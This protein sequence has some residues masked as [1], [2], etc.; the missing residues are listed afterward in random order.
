MKADSERTP[1]S[2]LDSLLLVPCAHSALGRKWPESLQGPSRPYLGLK[3]FVRV[4]EL[5]ASCSPPKMIDPAVAT[6]AAEGNIVLWRGLSLCRLHEGSLWWPSCVKV[7]LLW[8]QRQIVEY[9]LLEK[10]FGLDNV[11]DM[12]KPKKDFNTERCVPLSPPFFHSLFPSAGCFA[13][14]CNTNVR[15]YFSNL[16]LFVTLAVLLAILI[17]CNVQTNFHISFFFVLFPQTVSRH[18]RSQKQAAGHM[19][20]L[21]SH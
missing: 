21:L 2:M 15:S 16:K 6:T 11:M 4:D 7:G 17:S 20:R 10:T 8:S 12:L 5:T 19:V 18:R 3:A 9:T 13:P 1:T 14:W